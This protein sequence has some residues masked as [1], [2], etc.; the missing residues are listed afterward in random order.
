MT[1]NIQRFLGGAEYPAKKP[2]LLQQARDNHAPPEVLDTFEHL[3]RE[4]F[5][6]PRA[7]HARRLRPYAAGFKITLVQPSSRS[8]KCW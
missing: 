2:D 1:A 7:Q 3:R 4:Q 8:S 6:G 5:G